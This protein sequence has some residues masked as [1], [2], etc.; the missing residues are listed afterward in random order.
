LRCP[1]ATSLSWLLERYSQ[2]LVRTHEMIVG[3]PLFQ[4]DEELWNGFR[5]NLGAETQPEHRH[6]L[7]EL[8]Q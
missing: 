4:V 6:T 1:F 7:R 5:C 8:G 2:C 3:S